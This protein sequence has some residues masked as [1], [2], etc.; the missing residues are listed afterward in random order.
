MAIRTWKAPSNGSII[1][2]KRWDTHFSRS[3]PLPTSPIRAYFEDVY[4]KRRFPLALRHSRKTTK[5]AIYRDGGAALVE[6]RFGEGLV[7]VAG[8][9]INAQ[10]T[11][12]PS[13][14]AEFVPLMLQLV[15]YAQKR[16]DV[17]GPAIVP[18]DQPAEFSISNSWMPAKAIVAPPRQLGRE[19]LFTKSGARAAAV[20]EQ[21]R[22]GGFYTVELV[23][24]GDAAKKATSAFAVNLDP[25]ESET[26]RVSD[27]DLKTWLPNARWTFESWTAESL[28]LGVKDRR[29]EWWRWIIYGL[30]AVISAEL[31]LATLRGGTPTGQ[32]TSIDF[33]KI[34]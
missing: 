1:A 19:I 25:S 34:K 3:F 11:N 21:T 6:S 22:E 23:S 18:A 12:L 31:L 28:Q 29:R 30:F 9:P 7:I 33:R 17:E 32:R 27:E 8:F 13:N 2:K 14:E 20:F 5:L 24:S 16:A 10:W 4:I 15:N 26:A